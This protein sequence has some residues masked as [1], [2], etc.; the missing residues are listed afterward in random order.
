MLSPVGHEQRYYVTFRL[1]QLREGD[2]LHTVF[3]QLQADFQ[4]AGKQAVTKDLC[5]TVSQMR[6]KLLVY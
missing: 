4:C 1:K 3:S 5:G 6:H 2:L